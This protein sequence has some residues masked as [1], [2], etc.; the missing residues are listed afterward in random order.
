MKAVGC[1]LWLI[2][3]PSGANGDGED[4]GFELLDR[5]SKELGTYLGTAVE[6]TDASALERYTQAITVFG[7]CLQNQND[8]NNN[9]CLSRLEKE[10]ENLDRVFQ[11][12]IVFTHDL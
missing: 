12:G 5:T 7:E 10:L 11:S 4:G 8:D 6:A 9:K 2:L 1:L 3:S